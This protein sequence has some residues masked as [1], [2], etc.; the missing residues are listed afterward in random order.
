MAIT[1][2][3]DHGEGIFTL[4]SL[5]NRNFGI[6]TGTISFDD[7]YPAGGEDV[8]EITG[9]FDRPLGM[10]LLNYG[11]YQFAYIYQTDKVAIG[12]TVPTLTSSQ[13]VDSYQDYE[14]T[15]D[16]TPDGNQLY[17]KFGP[18]GPYLCCNMATDTADK[19]LDFGDGIYV[20]ID[21]DASAATGNG[22]AA[23]TFDDD[24]TQPGRLLADL[25]GGVNRDVYIATSDP[26][27]FLQITN[28]ASGGAAITYD[29]GADERLECNCAGAAN[30][31]INLAVLAFEIPDGSD[32]SGL[33]DIPF[34]A[35][36]YI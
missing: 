35:W 10:V 30:A 3:Y 2:E 18:T 25:S 19:I 14:V 17:V 24:A 20:V 4:Q 29:D 15:H 28:A 5:K 27:Y 8:S 36:G 33:T 11:Y 31:D 26:R 23:V 22:S 32:A 1:I 34:F 12:H 7:D 6:I 13:F 9:K 21:H 16:G